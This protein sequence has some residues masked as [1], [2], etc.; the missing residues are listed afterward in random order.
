MKRRIFPCALALVLLFP[1]GVQGQTRLTGTV[2]DSAGNPILLA[3]VVAG[4]CRETRVL[5][6]TTAD[7]TGAFALA[8][9]RHDCDTLLLTVRAL[10]YQTLALR[11]AT[12]SAGPRD[13]RLGGSVLREVVVRAA[14]PPVVV[15]SD[16]TEFR[17][18]S[19]SDSTEFSVEDLLKKIPGGRVSEN[20]LI[21]YNGKTVER[22]LIEGDDLFS[23]QYPL[24]TRNLRADMVD[25]IQA[26]DR[27]Q[28]NPCSKASRSPTAWYST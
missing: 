22:V 25:K 10:G 15:R 13:L 27:Y 4:H 21:S 20:G 5:A 24:A 18:A 23:L 11:W 9:P 1:L 17:A 12:A 19:F 6:Y 28:E 3:S 2:R 8:L 14:A 16:T 26:I 7:E